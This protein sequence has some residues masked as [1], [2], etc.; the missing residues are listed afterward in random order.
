M[1]AALIIRTLIDEIVVRVEDDALDLVI[2]WA[3]G[4][5]TPMRVRKN[6]AGQHRWGRTSN[7]PASSGAAGILRHRGVCRASARIRNKTA[8]RRNRQP[9]M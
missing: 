1:A 6:R 9:R 4:D 5:H 7:K 2:R 8:R 3:G